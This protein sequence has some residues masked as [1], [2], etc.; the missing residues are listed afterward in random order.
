MEIFIER[1]NEIWK[2]N[3]KHEFVKGNIQYERQFQAYLFYYLR[4]KLSEEYGFWIEPV[5]YLNQ[6]GLDKAKPDL[7]VTKSKEII[8][9][10]ELKFS[11]WSFAKT[12]HD[13]EKFLKFEKAIKNKKEITISW[14]PYSDNWNKQKNKEDKNLNFHFIP[15]TYKILCVVANK[16][17]EGLK[18]EYYQDITNFRLYFGYIDI[19]SVQQFDIT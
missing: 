1:L 16:D 4:S 3:I 7:I 18:K 15:E 8:A 10:I 17:S 12:L 5:L 19:D 9:I 6:Y 2:N 13:R 14:I 11:P